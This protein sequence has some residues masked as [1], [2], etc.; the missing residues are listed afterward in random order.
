[1]TWGGLFQA[2]PGRIG[3]S[4]EAAMRTLPFFGAIA[5]LLTW[6]NGYLLPRAA[7][8]SV[9]VGRAGIMPPQGNPADIQLTE[10]RPPE[11]PYVF[12]YPWLSHGIG[13]YEPMPF[14]WEERTCADIDPAAYAQDLQQRTNMARAGGRIVR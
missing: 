12:R 11:E 1:M 2:R 13:N 4:K 8:V 6:F 9:I 5:I 7:G 14:D 3:R 10:S